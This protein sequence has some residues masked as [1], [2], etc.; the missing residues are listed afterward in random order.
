M[1]NAKGLDVTC[2][3]TFPAHRRTREQ[4]AVLAVGM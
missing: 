3:I 4:V 1:V 2:S